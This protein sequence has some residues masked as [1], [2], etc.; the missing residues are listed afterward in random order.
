MSAARCCAALALLGVGAG[1]F[2]HRNLV[3]PWS[4]HFRRVEAPI[5]PKRWK[6]GD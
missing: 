6:S 2:E 5:K 4:D 3:M 1:Y